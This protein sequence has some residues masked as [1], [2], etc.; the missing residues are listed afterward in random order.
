MGGGVDGE[1]RGR[2]GVSHP[3]GVVLALV[4]MCLKKDT[5]FLVLYVLILV[6]CSPNRTNI[7]LVICRRVTNQN[8]KGFT[9]ENTFEIPTLKN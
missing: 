6:I 2:T 3:N 7:I 5:Y 8:M 1:D 4:V 9:R